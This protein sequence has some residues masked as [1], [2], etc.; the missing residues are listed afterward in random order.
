MTK[1]TKITCFLVAIGVFL[2]WQFGNLSCGFSGCL[3]TG[4]VGRDGAYDV[5]CGYKPD[6][7]NGTDYTCVR[8]PAQY[9]DPNVEEG[10]E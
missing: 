2:W 7:M 9:V 3:P 10:E 1:E 5:H 4:Y 8:K 6:G